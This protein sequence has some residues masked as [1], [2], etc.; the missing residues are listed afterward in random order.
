MNSLNLAPI[1][2]L[3]MRELRMANSLQGKGKLRNFG[4]HGRTNI[5]H[6]YRPYDNEVYIALHK[7]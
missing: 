4:V 3:I 1:H 6:A 2:F 7:S 5:K